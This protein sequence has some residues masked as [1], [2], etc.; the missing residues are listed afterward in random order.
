MFNY[1]QEYENYWSRADRWGSHSFSDPVPVAEQILATCGV[2]KFLDIGAGMGLLVRTLLGRGIDAYGMDVARNAVA[3]GNRFAPGRFYPGSVLAIPAG[4]ESFDTIICTDCLEHISE[5]DVPKALEELYRVAR[6]YIYIRLSTVPDRDEKWHICIHDRTWWETRFFEAGFRKHPMYYQAI[7]YE[8]LE[9]DG[10]QITLLFEKIPL[11][12]LRQYPLEIL[13]AERDLHMDM[14][15]E[16][17]RRSDAHVARYQLAGEFVRPGDIILDAACGMGYGS[18]ILQSTTASAKIIGVDESDFAIRY[19]AE[20][21]TSFPSTAEFVRGDV[22]DL[23]F[24][25]DH[26]VDV[27]VS[28]ETL[29]HLRSPERFFKE[30]LRVLRPGGRVIVSVP[31]NWTDET[32][33]DPNP[34]HHHVYT[35]DRL[36]AEISIHFMPESAYAQIAGGGMKLT[37][38]PRRLREI[39]IDENPSEEAEWYLMVSMKNPLTGNGMPYL[40]TA[41]ST[42]D[43]LPAFN[44]TAFGRDYLNPW[45]VKSM[46][47]IGMRNSNTE[48][49]AAI[50]EETYKNSPSGS[51]DQGAALCVQ[52]YQLLEG[53]SSSADDVDKMLDKIREYLGKANQGPHGVRWSVS[54]AYVKGML[55][56]NTGRLGEAHEAFVQC[57]RMDALQYS[58]L[59][60]TKTI[61][62][63]FWAGQ[64]ALGDGQESKAAEYWQHALADARRALAGDWTNIW[65]SPDKPVPFGLP[66]ASS[67]LDKASRCA[68]G[69]IALKSKRIRPGF[70]WHELK[71]DKESQWIELLQTKENWYVPELNRLSAAVEILLKTKQTWYEPELTRLN[72]LVNDVEPHM[73]GALDELKRIKSTRAWK[74]YRFYKMVRSKF[75]TMMHHLIRAEF[76]TI[77]LK[78][79]HNFDQVR[80]SRL[81]LS[82]DSEFV[83]IPNPLSITES[84]TDKLLLRI[85]KD[86]LNL[87]RLSNELLEKVKILDCKVSVII[88]CY[89]YG[90]YVRE[91][92]ES[93]RKQTYPNIEIIVVNDGST[94]P[95]TLEVLTELKRQYVNVLQLSNQGLSMAR[96]NGAEAATGEYLLFLDADDRIDPNAIS[97]LLYHL[98]LHPEAAYA[99]PYQRLFGDQNLVWACQEY[100]AYDLLWANHPS[101]CSLIRREVFIRSNRYRP[102]MKHGYED[103]ELWL[104]LASRKEYGHCVASPVFEHRRHG[105]TMTHDAY[106]N[107]RFLHSRILDL[108]P[109]LYTAENITRLKGEWRPA[110]SVI[111]P[112][113]NGHKYI[114]ETIES[115]TNQTMNDFEVILIN[116]GSDHPESIDVLDKIRADNYV[117]VVD[118]QH[119][120]LSAARNRGALEARAEYLMFLDSDDLLDKSAIEK[121]MLMAVFHPLA[122]FIYSGVVHFGDIEGTTIVPFNPFRLVKEN[123]LTFTCLIN[124]SVYMRLGGMD[125]NITDSYEDYDF[126]LRLISEGFQGRLLPEPLFM[127]RRHSES[128]RIRLLEK[129]TDKSML[130]KIR[131]RHPK[132]YGGPC[133]DKSSEKL[134]EYDPLSKKDMLARNI[135]AAYA[136]RLENEVAYE[137]F[138]RSDLPNPFPFVHWNSDKI[139]ILYLMP[140]FV[141]GGAEQVDLDILRGLSRERFHVTLVGCEAAKHT[142]YGEFAKAVDEIVL[143]PS[144]DLDEQKQEQLVSY[145]LISRSIDIT[146]NR[147]THVGYRLASNWKKVTS[148]V[149]FVDLM[150]LHAYGEDWVRLSA[151]Y[152]H[153]LDRRYVISLDLKEYAAKQYQLESDRFE[154]IYC[155]VDPDQFNISNNVRHNVRNELNV[156]QDALLVGFIGRFT[157][158]KNPMAWLD[159]ADAIGQER[160]EI[161]FVMIGDGELLEAC[162]TKASRLRIADRIHFLGYKAEI[163]FYIAALDVLLMTSGYEGLPLVVI[164]ALMCGVPVV[165]SD[166]GAIRECLAPD[167]GSLIHPLADASVYTKAVMAM[168]WELSNDPSLRLRCRDRVLKNFDIHRMRQR[169]KEELEA[170]ASQVNRKQRLEDYVIHLMDGPII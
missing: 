108:N 105:A 56:M 9:H 83:E 72:K 158:Q 102:E 96:N 100:N 104:S 18:A 92:V 38:R 93:V 140:Y 42:Y 71:R 35:W 46:I 78:V 79:W 142:W 68:Y 154:V 44:I 99:Y 61:D 113:Y 146:F 165:A 23:K 55:L 126:W 136:K 141:Y 62:A 15:R 41:F 49:L 123:Y 144:F 114:R 58:P 81:S 26:S 116:D 65:G 118:C 91:A 130:E 32:G 57:A 3:E 52:A 111:I 132:L 106:K 75:N 53:R 67:L 98:Q 152:H 121:L 148:Q 129:S 34:H 59:L 164:E 33:K 17:G 90:R 74:V 13:K 120:G 161:Y 159:V 107:R 66:E 167:I 131:S 115:L 73:Q 166:V 64:I 110:L 2:G 20:N 36:R 1:Q 86:D 128:N 22:E 149:R 14:L 50:A 145:L 117:R 77:L 156:P 70:F 155:G 89:N 40:E 97:L 147:N 37:D 163:Q 95:E 48:S 19:A 43:D 137:G 54:L 31:N 169:Y 151:P 80:L 162:R 157:E 11:Q 122:A 69:L 160:K 8:S 7:P 76:R 21:F 82:S 103:W 112:Y 28:F 119:R 30:V 125:E 143:L 170:L 94:D 138:R 101:V 45:L 16:T 124:R 168:I 25:A 88:P 63:W 39:D 4:D 84:Y 139:H 5:T 24:L 127:Y 27:V 135:D 51:V 29:E 12:V 60:M 133:M 134:I 6:R 87:N 85:E 10:G 150:H 109:G 153:N 47:A